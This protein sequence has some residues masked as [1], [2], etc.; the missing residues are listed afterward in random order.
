[1]S[2]WFE[3]SHLGGVR[4]DGPD[5][6]TFAQSQF[7]VD[8]AAMAADSW[9]PLAWCDAKGRVVAFMLARCRDQRVDLVLPAGQVEAVAGKLP[10]YAIGRT[11]EIRT[12]GPVCGTLT[13]PDDAER[14]RFDPER[15]L[16]IASD[17]S[18]PGPDQLEQ[19]RLADL[20]HG[21]PWLGAA[22]SGR[23]L[24]QMLG[25]EALD[26]ISYTKG[27]YPGQEVIARVHFLGRVKQHTV[28]MMIREAAEIV[29]DT[30]IGTSSDENVGTWLWGLARGKRTFGLAMVDSGIQPGAHV[31]IHADSRPVSARVTAPERLC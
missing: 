22:T 14:L 30:R 11:V 1:M 17:C 16:T 20:R 12:A 25:L 23:Y 4:L 28:G 13:A 8:V 9:S 10:L 18:K 24:P 6:T 31:R 19:W 5:A 15:A 26:A 21:L 29:P 27:C 7:S 2:E 3:L